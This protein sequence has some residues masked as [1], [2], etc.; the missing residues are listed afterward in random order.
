[1]KPKFVND[2]GEAMGREMQDR[3]TASMLF[4]SPVMVSL[5]QRHHRYVEAMRAGGRTWMCFGD[6][7]NTLM[8]RGITDYEDDLQAAERAA[9]LL[10]E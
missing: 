1:M 2:H 6:F 3:V 7:V 5:E 8:V 10:G 4:F 9:G